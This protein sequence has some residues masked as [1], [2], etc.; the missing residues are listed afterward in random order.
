MQALRRRLGAID[1]TLM[2]C[3]ALESFVSLVVVL[4]IALATVA[5]SGRRGPALHSAA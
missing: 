4:A 1:A 5:Y 2:A 3:L